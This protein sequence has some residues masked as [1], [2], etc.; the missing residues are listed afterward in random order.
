MLVATHIVAIQKEPTCFVGRSQLFRI[1]ITF[2][3]VLL[4]FL[5]SVSSGQD[6]LFGSL[7]D[8][9]EQVLRLGRLSEFEGVAG[10]GFSLVGPQWYTGAWFSATQKSRRHVVKLSG[11]LRAGLYGAY[12]PDTDELYDV[13]RIVQVL[14]FESLRGGTYVRVGPLNRTRFGT[15]HLVN[16]LN[17]D[18]VYDERTVGFEAQMTGKIFTVEGFSEDVFSSGLM[19]ARISVRPLS[20][21]SNRLGTLS[22]GASAVVDRKFRLTETSKVDGQ[23]ADIRMNAYDTGGFSFFP[24]FSFA[25]LP[26]YG[27]GYSFG[28]DIEH[29]NFV[30]FARL[31]FRL[32]LHYNSSDFRTGY[33][34]AFYTA[35]SHR[36]NILSENESALAGYQLREIDRGNSIESEIRVMVFNRFEFWYA[37]LRYHGVQPLSEYHLRLLFTS[38]RFNLSIGQDR[39]GLV[40]FRSLFD[41]LGDENRM[42]FEFEYRVIGPLWA[43]VNADYTYVKLF[44]SVD[45]IPQHI[46]QRRFSPMVILRYPTI[47]R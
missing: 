37:F 17:T 11:M 27:Q 2:V 9:S 14:R 34:G 18:A 10:A 39:R 22:I 44:E 7:D 28:A 19:G 45:S 32:A 31:H 47:S 16:F 41:G 36:A 24:F 3:L 15:G 1:R 25:R 26:N 23:E 46:V 30:D 40:G 8:P 5:P 21:L 29:D 42:R 38:N 20:N 4:L 12:E 13:A 33:F 6:R 43:R 35:G